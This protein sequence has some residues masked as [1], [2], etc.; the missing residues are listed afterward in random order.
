[1]E[2]ARDL[3]D[4]SSGTDD[5][6]QYHTTGRH[7][8]AAGRGVEY[9]EREIER[10]QTSVDLLRHKLEHLD[11]GSSHDMSQADEEEGESKMKAI[12]AR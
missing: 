7:R 12:I 8:K 2:S 1:M 4:S 3:S 5:V 11:L 10:L 9:Y 6:P